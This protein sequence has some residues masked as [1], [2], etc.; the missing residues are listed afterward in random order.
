[1]KPLFSI[2]IPCFNCIE[3]IDR[4]L[5]SFFEQ[6][7]DEFEL[8]L[9]DD[10]SSD[11]S[12]DY[13]VSKYAHKENLTIKRNDSNKGPAFSRN[14]GIRIATGEFVCFCDSDDWVENTFF[15][16]L[17]ECLESLHPDIVFFNHRK[18][19]KNHS[20]KDFII[21]RARS[22][23]STKEALVNNLQS[24]CTLCVKTSIAKDN[25][26][27]DLRNGEDYAIV[28]IWIQQSKKIV[29]LKD[30]LYNYFMSASSASRRPSPFAMNNLFLSFEHVKNN[31]ESEY[32]EEI[33]F[34]GVSDCL[35]GAVLTGIKAKNKKKE[36]LDIPSRFE[37]LY[38]DWN[39]NKYLPKL[40]FLKRM[41]LRFVKKRNFLFLNLYVK[42]H[43]L[44]LKK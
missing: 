15:N 21:Y 7:F 8:I 41:F 25:P 2:I 6:E 40:P 1:M 23:I 39:K 34:I 13:L 33:E 18:I 24:L 37:L 43:S 11:G 12:F 27:P 16:V 28:P 44:F 26:I 22:E 4:C 5:N 10:C 31:S 35:Y 29:C 17:I 32:S 38:P 42:L 30:T 19:F 9:V 14:E 3:T 36:I 20:T